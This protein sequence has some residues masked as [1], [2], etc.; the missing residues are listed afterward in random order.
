M[1]VERTSNNILV[2]KK[3]EIEELTQ[4]IF[5]RSTLTAHHARLLAIHLVKS[6]WSKKGGQ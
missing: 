4:E 5:E 3:A 2:E 1:P 6:G